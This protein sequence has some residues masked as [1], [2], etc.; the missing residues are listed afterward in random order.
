MRLEDESEDMITRRV[1]D[2]HDEIRNQVLLER[3]CEA[4][5]RLGVFGGGMRNR[6]RNRRGA[7]N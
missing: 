6:N 2:G 5:G 1:D 3:V 4:I 7:H